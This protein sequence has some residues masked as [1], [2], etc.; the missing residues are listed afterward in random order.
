M[1]QNKSNL[2]YEIL[3]SRM[4]FRLLLLLLSLLGALLGLT[5][6]ILQKE[7][8]DILM[9]NTD[10]AHLA[11]FSS[12]EPPSLIFFSC[13]CL[14]L[15]QAFIQITNYLG[16]QESLIMQ[17]RLVRRLYQKTLDLK[18]DALSNY[19]TGNIVSLYTTDVPAATILLEQ[20]IPFGA[21][22]L[23]PFFLAPLAIST[24][25]NVPIW[26]TLL[27]MA[28]ASGISI[29]LSFRQAKFF[30]IF[31]NLAAERIG[32]V[33]EWIQSIRTIRI[34]G[35]MPLFEGRIFKKRQ[36][37][38]ENRI[39]MVTNGQIMNSLSTSISFFLNITT[40]S[41][42][43]YIS[44]RQ[45]S[46]GE[47]LASLWI[48]GLFLVRP[49][50]QLPW[51]FTFA[52]DAWTSIRRLEKFLDLAN[53]TPLFENPKL[54]PPIDSAQS[55]L[56][57]P[58]STSLRIEGMGLSFKN[59]ILLKDIELKIKK[60]EF[61]AIVGEVGSGK[62]LFLLSL[63]GETGAHFRKYDI[64]GKAVADLSPQELKASFCFVPQEGFIMSASLQENIRFSYGD[65]ATATDTDSEMGHR[66]LLKRAQFDLDVETLEKGLHTKI[67]ERGVNLSGGQKQR[68]NLARAL[69]RFNEFPPSSEAIILLDDCLSAVDV[70]TE[71]KLI[72]ELISGVWKN[73]TRLLVTHRL[74]VL[75]Y[76]DRVL[77]FREG[78]IVDQGS[79]SELM[80]RNEDFREFTKSTS[81]K[82]LPRVES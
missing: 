55:R 18:I 45:P 3:V 12:L 37:E 23:F 57:T 48:V 74:S 54:R 13:I 10:K 2:L 66:Q 50:R 81:S 47:L 44:G 8:I 70:N 73:S 63:L 82:E 25:L 67:G 22:T 42:L 53:T 72:E 62:S 41:S 16:A 32:L 14:L 38:T 71:H 39:A 11:L 7:F 27:L 64:F 58:V 15:S 26:P 65:A 19:Q 59:Q 78:Q 5:A 6:P 69:Y 29:F 51:F 76:A 21:S 9:G 17:G 68:V 40:V 31:K 33:S 52:F 43:I 4:Q 36:L 1:V 79:F 20:T 60:G 35:W 80:A 46:S 77:F 49:F 30:F 24:L 34:L 75:K 28:A 56:S 61:I